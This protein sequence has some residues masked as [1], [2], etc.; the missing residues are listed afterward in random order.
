[1]FLSL[2]PV[3]ACNSKVSASERKTLNVI[4]TN[5]LLTA[6]ALLV[7]AFVEAVV[8][9]LSVYHALIV[10]NLSWVNNASL[11]TSFL[12]KMGYIF[13]RKHGDM[14]GATTYSWAS[15]TNCCAGNHAAL[16]DGSTG[17]LS[18]GQCA[19]FGDQLECITGTFLIVF[20]HDIPVMS[21][22]L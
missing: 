22:S 11:A 16:Y 4:C 2:V 7:S 3:F 12:L 18:V 10:L 15:G 6:C 17:N 8:F 14:P 21:K 5:L 19:E 20:G 9:G 1:V 13:N